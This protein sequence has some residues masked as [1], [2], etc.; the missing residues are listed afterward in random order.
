ML[1]IRKFFHMGRPPRPVRPCF[2]RALRAGEG[3]RNVG[4]RRGRERYE[5]KER[6]RINGPALMSPPPATKSRRGGYGWGAIKIGVCAVALA[7]ASS[8]DDANGHRSRS[9]TAPTRTLPATSWGKDPRRGR[10]ISRERAL[11]MRIRAPGR[12]DFGDSALNSTITAAE[13]RALNHVH[14]HRNLRP[15]DWT[16]RPRS[17]SNELHEMRFA[18][19]AAS[20]WISGLR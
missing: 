15:R 11:E 16:A 19:K 17:S 13:G 10:V 18:R 12:K 2:S 8:R 5:R 1:I 3:A 9:G 7:P 20:I 4:T 14:S 6:P